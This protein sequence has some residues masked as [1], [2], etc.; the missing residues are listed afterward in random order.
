MPGHL[1]LLDNGRAKA[2][3]ACSRCG[4][5]SGGTQKEILSQT[6]QYLVNLSFCLQKHTYTF[7][8]RN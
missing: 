7:L 4:G 3:G 1:A 8:K 5:Q 6:D 2:L